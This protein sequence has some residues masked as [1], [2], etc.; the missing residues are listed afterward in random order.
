MTEKDAAQQRAVLTRRLSPHSTP[1]DRGSSSRGSY[2]TGESSAAGSIFND[3]ALSPSPDESSG[4]RIYSPNHLEAGNTNGNHGKDAR[5][6]RAPRHRSNGAFLLQDAIRNDNDSDGDQAPRLRHVRNLPPAR[7][8]QDYGKASD[9]SGASTGRDA[10]LG[11]TRLDSPSR[12]NGNGNTSPTQPANNLTIRKRD[13]SN[14]RPLSGSSFTSV[15]NPPLDIDSAQIVN[16]ALN[17]SESRR[18]VSRRTV[19]SQAIPTLAQLPDATTGANLKNHLQQQRRMSRTRSPGPDRALTP[20]LPSTS[21]LGSPL[22]ATFDMGREGTFRNHF[23]ASTLARAQKAKEHLELM[24]QYRR[25]LELVPPIQPHHHHHSRPTTASPPTSSGGIAKIPTYGSSEG[26]LR[27]GRPYNPL[28]YIRNRKVRARERK[29][30]DGET[31]GFGDIVKVADWV[32]EV[33]RWAAT[34][35]TSAEGCTLPPFADADALERQNA[36]Q[37]AANAN[38][39]RRPRLDWVIDAADLLADAYWLEQD[40]HKQLIEDRHWRRI[41]P[42]H[43][44]LHRPLS[45]Q[46]EDH[47]SESGQTPGHKENEESLQM[48]DPR[49][50]NTKLAKSD[51]DHST[52]SARDRAR[53]KLHDLTGHHHHHHHRHSSSMHSH[54]DWRHGKTSSDLS[55]SENEGRPKKERRNRADTLTSSHQDI[56]EKQ[57]LEMIAMEARENGPQKPQG[58]GNVTPERNAGAGSHPQSRQHSRKP[59]IAD[60][61]ESDERK[62]KDKPR[63]TPLHLQRATRSSLEIPMLGRRISFEVDTSLP[64]SPDGA[65]RGDPFIPALGGDLSAAS[66]RA[67]SPTRNPFSKVRQIF[68]ERSRER[69]GDRISEEKSSAEYLPSAPRTPFEASPES[70]GERRSTERRGSSRSP[71]RRIVQRQTGESHKSHRSVTSIKLRSDEPGVRGIFKGARIDNVIRGSV[72]KI[73]DLIW[74]KESDNAGDVPSE[75]EGTTTDE[76]DTEQRGRKRGETPLSRTASIRSQGMR[77]QNHK[78]YLDVMPT[79]EPASHDKLKHTQSE[80]LDLP[81]NSPPSASRKS[82]RFD[83]LKPPRIDIMSASPT[84]SHGSIKRLSDVSELEPLSGGRIP[85]MK[86]AD[87][88]F[89]PIITMP[90][91]APAGRPRS[92]SNRSRHWSISDH[93]PAPERAPMSKREVAR[94]RALV[95]SS[96]IKAME[97]TRRANEP[98]TVFADQQTLS[99]NDVQVANIFWPEIAKLSPDPGSVLNKAVPQTELYQFAAKTLG[100]SIQCSGQE[101]QKSADLFVSDTVPALHRR[102][103]DV[104]RRVATDLSAMTRAAADEADETSR[105]LT[106]GQ[107]L[108]I[109]HTVDVIET[110]LRRRRRRF[111][112]V[113]RGMWLAV[114][115]VLVGFMWYV[116]FVVMILRV[117]WGVG[118]GVVG[119]VKWLLWFLISGYASED[120]SDVR[121]T[122]RLS[123]QV[124]SDEPSPLQTRRRVCCHFDPAPARPTSFTPITMS[125][126]TPTYIPSPNWDIPF[127]SDLVVLGRLIKDPKNPQSEVPGSRADPIAPPT[128]YEEEKTDWE[129]TSERTR[130]GKIGL[131]TKCLQVV[132]GGLSLG[133]LKSSLETHRFTTLETKYFLPEDDYLAQALEDAGVQAYFE[134]H[135]WRKPVYLITG[136]KIV[137]G[138][139]REHREQRRTFGPGP[140][141]GGRDG[142]GCARRGG[143]R[144]ELPMHA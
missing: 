64:N 27:L 110:M 77:Q 40:H 121:D 43:V 71:P 132:E 92:G 127:D 131:W 48:G 17:L 103:E 122:F 58:S 69:V 65:G 4:R 74:R 11:I 137:R 55:D 84:S 123:A 140:A 62:S 109:K 63:H 115:W 82:P 98:H 99:Q 118:K 6:Q 89:K 79:F 15:T 24:A 107:R 113:R 23:T 38:K 144:G 91:F 13:E 105:D 142:R 101:W 61:S 35:Q 25:L 41:F 81:D 87:K 119:A 51:T 60:F 54:H 16:M 39:P 53:Q 20:R 32:D 78:T 75:A 90:P 44:D 129:T 86:E 2:E 52:V 128:V 95:L 33:A 139:Q 138:G 72:S 133:Q 22:Q 7:R 10:G 57:M 80:P 141:E 85:G 9:K 111:R 106:L 108:K 42:Q 34:G 18:Q 46:N 37:L 67:N 130:S 120:I 94:L 14:G 112:W 117:F 126:Y 59:S 88:R 49:T 29:A 135:N 12:R 83:R 8:T 100:S 70:S 66:S 104:R 30:I 19:P 28:Q 93:S 116:W 21:I 45:R 3:T 50:S 31:Q 1:A 134:V 47:G 143:A 96:G 73:G 26:S 68:R 5:K 102:V 36:T 114:E 76:S 125:S 56:L 97:I 124:T 136:I